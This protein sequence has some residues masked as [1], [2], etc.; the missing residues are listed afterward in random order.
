MYIETTLIGATTQTIDEDKNV[1]EA[2]ERTNVYATKTSVTRQ[3]WSTAGQLGHKADFRLIMHKAE[4][5]GQSKVE[6]EGK[7]YAIYRTYES[8]TDI[9]LYCEE[10]GGV[11]N[12]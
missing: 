5:N 1:I 4:Y 6:V 3:E 10:Q 11:T 2:P 9:E 8:G 12:G 7:T